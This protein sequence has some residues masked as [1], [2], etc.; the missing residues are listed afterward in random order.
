M[1]KD[2][3]D[4]VHATVLAVVPAR[5]PGITLDDYLAAMRARLPKAKGWDGSASAGWWAMAIKLDM[6]A[7]AS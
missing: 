2:Q 1:A 3:Y 7:R 5:E 6:E 4:V